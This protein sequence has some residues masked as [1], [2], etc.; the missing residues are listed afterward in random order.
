MLGQDVMR[1]AGSDALGLTR[2]DLDVTDRDAVRAAIGAGRHRHQLRRLDQR[3]RRGG[4]P[5]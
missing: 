5:G 2:A 4:A 1:L 3:R